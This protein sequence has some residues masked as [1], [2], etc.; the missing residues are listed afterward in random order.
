MW[1]GTELKGLATGIPGFQSVAVSISTFICCIGQTRSPTCRASWRRLRTCVRKGKIRAWGVS[2]FNVSDMGRLLNV[3]H[4][5]SCA[6]NQVPYS[7]GD[8]AIEHDLLPWCTRHAIPVN[9]VFATRGSEQHVAAQSHARAYWRGTCL[10]SSLPRIRRPG[11][12]KD[13][14]ITTYATR[15]AGIRYRLILKAQKVRE[16]LGG[17]LGVANPFPAKPLPT[18]TL[19][20]KLDSVTAFQVLCL[21]GIA[22]PNAP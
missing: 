4:G 15:Q 18:V 14:A 22:Y 8:R 12:R 7:L 2:N 19:I 9:G 13:A 6:T 5:D 17:D 10:F 16:R 3:P 21:P 20:S 1:Q 11:A